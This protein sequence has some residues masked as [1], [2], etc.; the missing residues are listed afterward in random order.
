MRIACKAIMN[1]H[2]TRNEVVKC[3]KVKFATKRW[4]SVRSRLE[5]DRVEDRIDTHQ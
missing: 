1:V 3:N 4:E 2:V 5:I